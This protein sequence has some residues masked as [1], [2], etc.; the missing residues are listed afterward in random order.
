M[1]APSN[2][3]L[4]G[5]VTEGLK[6]SGERDPSTA[7]INRAKTE[8]IPEIKNDIW[9]RL[10]K[11]KVLQIVSHGVI[12]RGRSRYSYPADYSS[13]LT[14]TFLDGTRSGTAQGGAAGYIDLAA[15]EDAAD[16]ELIGLEILI[17]SGTGVASLSQITGYDNT[18]KRATVTPDFRTAP[19][20][21]STYLVI[22]REIP[23]EQR[24][25]TDY[26]HL[27]RLGM[28]EPRFFF[29]I[30]D[31]DYGEFSLDTPPAKLYGARLR[32]YA[33]IMRIDVDS[34][35]MTTLYRE[36]ESLWKQGIFAKMLKSVDDDRAMAEWSSYQREIAVIVN[37]E[38]Y[39]ADL[40]SVQDR[41]LDF[42]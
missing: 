35:V 21:G 26:E 10:K 39:G 34:T 4:D 22:T 17:T 19:A 16:G 1:A 3:T 33:N 18:T 24:P 14:L 20:S 31:E 41:V 38:K 27:R 36:W 8:W 7:L 42:K 37:T 12:S 40:S 15:S 25:V 28:G 23:I 32:Y 11:P 13:D 9:K 2:P 30:G 5:I 29:P 6:L